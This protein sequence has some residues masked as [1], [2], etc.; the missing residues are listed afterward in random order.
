MLRPWRRLGSTRLQDCRVFE[1]ERVRFERPEGGSE[2]S[3]YCLDAPDWINVIPLTEDERVLFV[4]QYRFGI[5]DLTLEIP[6]GMC[7]AGESPIEAAGR[8]LLEETGYRAAEIREIGWVHPNPSIQNNRCHSFV[9]RGLEK[10]RD[11]RPD[12]HEAFEQVSVPLGDVPRLI[13]AGSI[14]HALVLVAFHLLDQSRK[15]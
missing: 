12:P 6:G 2:E 11:P 8:E 3:F 9:A 7:D 14:S 13:A 1:V 15:A 10:V 4:R 5:E